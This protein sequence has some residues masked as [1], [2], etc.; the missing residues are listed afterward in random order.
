MPVPSSIRSDLKAL[1]SVGWRMILLTPIVV[2]LGFAV[3]I[4]A[5]ASLFLPPLYAIICLFTGDYFLSFIALV[6]WAL[7]L[8][9]GRMILRAVFEGFEHGSL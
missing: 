7:W 3:L 4:L 5:V 8:R 6:L 9:F 2:P 1:W